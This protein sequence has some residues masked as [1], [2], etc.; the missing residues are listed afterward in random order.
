LRKWPRKGGNI[1]HCEA[2]RS[3]EGKVPTPASMAFT[4]VGD[5]GRDSV[6]DYRAIEL[7]PWTRFSEIV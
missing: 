3:K 4:G 5:G 6:L 1:Y 2:E 7:L